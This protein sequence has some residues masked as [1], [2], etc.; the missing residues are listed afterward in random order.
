MA[1]EARPAGAA[2]RWAEADMAAVPK[3]VRLASG[4][5]LGIF[6]LAL[7]SE[8]L[9]A[10]VHVGATSSVMPLQ[11]S[12]IT[13]A[14]FAVGMALT[15]ARPVRRAVPLSIVAVTALACS[16]GI[17]S[18]YF[19]RDS[20]TIWPLQLLG[21]L[22]FSLSPPLL[23]FFWLQRAAPFGSRFVIESFGIAAVSLGCLSMLTMALEHTAALAFVVAL[24][25]MGA[26]LLWATD[27]A[28][29]P[30]PA[31]AADER[32]SAP[33]SAPRV[34]A[35]LG[36]DADAPRD[37]LAEGA[38]Q[39]KRN[40]ARTILRC[41]VKLA[42]YFCYALIFGCVHFSWVAMQD[43][44]S[45]GFW[46]QMGASVGSIACGGAALA[47]A[48]LRWG[49]ALESIMH[50]LLAVF[51]IVALWLATFLTSGFV[52][53]YLVLLNIAQKL[54]FLLI[55]IFGFPFAHSASQAASLSTPAYFS[56]FLGTFVSS[57]ISVACGTLELNLIAAM[58]LMLLLAVDVTGVAS[59]YSTKVGAR[60]GRRG[61]ASSPADNRPVYE[62]DGT[63][64]PA[65]L[66]GDTAADGAKRPA[67]QP[68][69]TERQDGGD[70]CATQ[71]PA[72]TRRGP[73]EGV[74]LLPYTCHLIASQYCFTRR[75]EEILQ[76]LVR[77]RTAAR[78]AET[79]CITTATTR[80]HLRN[81]YAKLGVHSQQ[82]VLD[83]YEEFAKKLQG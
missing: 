16:L 11:T 74:E 17:C 72:G 33:C 45:V 21:D 18:M 13:L 32:A 2:Q 20:P 43:E 1:G 59:L 30:Y 26:A 15:C 4:L 66:A 69:T 37:S 42:P 80:T 40:A 76:L 6:M 44:A 28:Q 58:A 49:R 34:L 71:S 23:V 50:L 47:L 5:I 68:E 27:R 83:M 29:E 10:L 35:G 81:I 12:L 36:A 62:G 31:S 52:F 67:W 73:A 82:D 46:V 63:A 8:R 7:E 79:L 51:A 60:Q 75:E 55:L 53:A 48:R 57:H 39:I 22:S 56:F 3:T 25:L 77:G 24:P 54:S 14:V 64:T 41:L 19:L 65:P 78:I 61:A 38:V 9:S 70:S